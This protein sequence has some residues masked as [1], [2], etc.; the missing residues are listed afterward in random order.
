M[1]DFSFEVAKRLPLAEGCLQLLKFA[2]ADV[3]DDVYD[4]YR[5][6]SYTGKIGFPDFVRLLAGVVLGHDDS[7]HQAFTA[8][9]AAD[10][11][12]ATLPAWYGNLGRLPIPLSQ[13]LFAT[14]AARLADVGTPAGTP[15]PACLDG[16]Q[17]VAVDGKKLK[18]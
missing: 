4:R 1:S 8:A 9:R 2:L 6:R 5:G 10:P 14:A 7:P 13:G 12:A 11:D 3:L 15:P 17:I 16:F 18:T